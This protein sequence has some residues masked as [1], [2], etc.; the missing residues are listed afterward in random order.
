MADLP[1]YVRKYI[2]LE[3]VRRRMKLS[4]EK[5]DADVRRAIEPY[6]A[7]VQAW[8]M[9]QPK[10]RYDI[11]DERL[12]LSGRVEFRSREE[13]KA[14]TYNTLDHN[15]KK[16]FL[17]VLPQRFPN[18]PAD[19]LEQISSLCTDFCWANRD[20]NLRTDLLRTF[21]DARKKRTAPNGATRAPAAKARRKK[22]KFD[23]LLLPPPAQ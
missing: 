22:A 7:H 19:V 18:I 6:L 15:N 9:A 14:L 5:Q 21:D 4:Y 20:K 3:D 12:G 23:H 10:A 17:T 1:D 11:R 2:E 13:F 16:F 8:V